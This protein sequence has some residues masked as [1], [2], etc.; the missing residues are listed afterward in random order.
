MAAVK[1]TAKTF[2][3]NSG[4]SIPGIGLGTWQSKPGQVE[5]AVEAA[6]RAGY[7]HIDTAFAYGNEKEVGEGIRA[8]GVPREEIWLTTKL[9]NPWHKRVAEGIDQ[10][11]KNLGTSYVDLY[12][13][14]WPCSLDPDHEGKAYV[15]WDFVDTW[16]E[17]QKL[18]GT[19]KVRN[20]GVS[21][22]GI[23]N[24]EKLLNDP[25]CKIVPAVNQIE[26]HPGNPSPKLVAY[27][28]TH[29]IHTSGYSPLGSSDSPLYSNETINAIAKAKG[30]TPQ[31]ILLVWGLQ[32]GWSV[33]PK[34]VTTS[35]V[36]ANYDL[37]GWS[38]SDDEVAKIDAIPDRFKVCQD[39]WLPVTVFYGDDE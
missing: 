5:K 18:V 39:G 28:N 20:I 27:N 14:H 2:K 22:F 15:D 29:G 34:S 23:K 36:E 12:L 31:Q 26:L 1:N 16:R 35:R 33:L 6:P 30:R 9:D 37:D 3:L 17:M 25:S 24:L 4:D 21:N 13:M 32:K 8:S 38:L 7:R 19:G 11:L 10:S